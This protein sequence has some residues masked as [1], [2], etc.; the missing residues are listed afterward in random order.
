MCIA[1]PVYFVCVIS[2]FSL[3]IRLGVVYVGAP[4]TSKRTVLRV[5]ETPVSTFDHL[6]NSISFFFLTENFFT[7]LVHIHMMYLLHSVV[8]QLIEK[9]GYQ[10]MKYH[11][12]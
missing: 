3:T 6:P 7:I 4:A 5:L 12:K 9:Q 8:S 2:L 11:P 10:M 1:V